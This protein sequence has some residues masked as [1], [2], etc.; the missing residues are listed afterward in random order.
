MRSNNSNGSRDARAQGFTGLWTVLAIGLVASIAM[1]RPTEAHRAYVTNSDST[2]V[3][4]IDRDTNKVVGNPIPVRRSPSGL[5]S[6]SDGK[7]VYVTNV[8]DNTVSVIDTEKNMVV[9]EPIKLGFSPNG[10]AVNPDGKK[11]QCHL[12]DRHGEEHS[13]G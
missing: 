13:G 5:T 7:H 3:S 8:G 11:A 10:V 9:G 12:G 4:V 2:D 6:T 1:A